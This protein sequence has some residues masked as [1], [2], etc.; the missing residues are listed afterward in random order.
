MSTE[1]VD[2]VV[3]D[4]ALAFVAA[5]GLTTDAGIGPWST[6]AEIEAAYV[7]DDVESGRNRLAIRQVIVR[8]SS[9][10]PVATLFLMTTT[11][12]QD[13]VERIKVGHYPTVEQYDEGCA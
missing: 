3:I 10:E 2:F 8:P 6:Q 12:N 4:G 9:G 1:A 5:T 11:G 13:Q 7:G